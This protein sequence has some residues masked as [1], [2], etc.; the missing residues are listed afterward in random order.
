[1]QSSAARCTCATSKCAPASLCD[2]GGVLVPEEG[3]SINS[4]AILSCDAFLREDVRYFY[5]LISF[6]SSTLVEFCLTAR[7]SLL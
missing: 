5:A 7:S 6:C 1:M 4:A 2:V 3:A